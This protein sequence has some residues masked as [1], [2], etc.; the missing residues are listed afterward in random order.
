M[1][2]MIKTI[3]IISSIFVLCNS[4]LVVKALDNS[5]EK[6]ISTKII[7]VS[8]KGINIEFT[9]FSSKVNNFVF[10]ISLKKRTSN[11]WKTV[12]FKQKAMFPKT[13]YTLNSKES[14]NIEILWK[15]YYENN[16]SAGVYKLIFVK[17]MVFEICEKEN[18]ENSQN[19]LSPKTCDIIE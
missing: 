16:L 5:D 11:G 7:S 18:T 17:P 13:L 10:S 15:D 14:C 3:A 1:K 4:I 19:A 6:Q 12:P 2:K 9:N 8:E